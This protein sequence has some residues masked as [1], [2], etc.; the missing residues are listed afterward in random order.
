MYYYHI[1]A[2]DFEV[3][4]D[5]SFLLLELLDR[6]LFSLFPFPNDKCIEGE[7]F[8]KNM[9]ISNTFLTVWTISN[10]VK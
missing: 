3:W 9:F 2:V 1:S 10:P 7:Y 4:N 8:S 6:I 5:H